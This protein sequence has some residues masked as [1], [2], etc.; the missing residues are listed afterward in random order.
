M[1]DAIRGVSAVG[2]D[3]VEL[4]Q[5]RWSHRA[6]AAVTRG[7]HDPVNGDHSNEWE[8]YGCTQHWS[9]GRRSNLLLLTL[10]FR[11]GISKSDIGT[12]CEDPM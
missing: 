10:H 2:S 9:L 7:R 4:G 5:G 11:A 6:T 8:I 12:R 1:S 3:S